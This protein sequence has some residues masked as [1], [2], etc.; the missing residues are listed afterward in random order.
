MKAAFSLFF[1]RFKVQIVIILLAIMAAMV[2][3]HWT[4][5]TLLE[6]NLEEAKTRNGELLVENSTLRSANLKAAEDIKIQNNAIVK[7]R[8]EAAE[9]SKRAEEAVASLTKKEKQWKVK[10]EDIFIKVP[11]STDNCL[12]TTELLDNYQAA[13]IEEEKGNQP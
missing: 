7:W 1:D 3:Y 2:A 13:R 5:I 10:Y 9:Q 6:R 11:T 4:V 8:I 12:N